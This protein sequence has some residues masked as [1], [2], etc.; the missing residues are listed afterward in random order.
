MHAIHYEKR[1][2]ARREVHI[3]RISRA[4]GSGSFVCISRQR[5]G[6]ESSASSLTGWRAVTVQ[7]PKI[8]ALIKAMLN[9]MDAHKAPPG[10]EDADE[11]PDANGDQ[12][13]HKDEL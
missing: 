13:A 2:L 7:D 10:S 3:F 4:A 12:P 9:A 6:A 1:D 8:Q 11:A 5:V